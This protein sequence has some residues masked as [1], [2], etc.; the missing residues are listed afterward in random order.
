MEDQI[1][2]KPVEEKKER[3]H[4]VI[5]TTGN[6]WEYFYS[7]EAAV[8][9]PT[10]GNINNFGHNV[11]NKGL[12]KEAKELFPLL[13][14]LV[15]KAIKRLGGHNSVF[16]YRFPT[17]KVGENV[18]KENYVF[19]FPTKYNHWDDKSNL[20]LIEF[21]ANALVRTLDNLGK[22][23]GID[24][25]V[26]PLVGCGCGSLDWEGEVKPILAKI[27]DDRFLVVKKEDAYE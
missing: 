7:G 21:S 24:K 16:L 19:T 12:A 6:L 20:S 9:I 27:L 18:K 15:G 17:D 10:N 26:L 4:C 13:P 5:E 3:E 25:V 1:D 2:L 8:V 22:V 14:K 23:L 11:M